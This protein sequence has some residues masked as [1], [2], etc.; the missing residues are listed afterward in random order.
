[1]RGIRSAR[2]VPTSHQVGSPPI[3]S[4]RL[5][6]DRG[7][8]TGASET[9][10]S[11][12]VPNTRS[13]SFFYRYRHE[14]CSKEYAKGSSLDPPE[15]KKKKKAS[16]V[17]DCFRGVISL[18]VVR[19]SPSRGDI[20][21]RQNERKWFVTTMSYCCWTDCARCGSANWRRAVGY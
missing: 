21:S 10:I 18:V 19:L 8:W 7:A 2:T 17:L 1:M 3:A 15:K 4:M 12:P 6:V 14:N 13:E 9:I 20:E 16:L 11:I 5:A